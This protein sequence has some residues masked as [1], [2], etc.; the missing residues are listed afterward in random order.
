[1]DVSP[2][3]APYVQVLGASLNNKKN[4]YY[5]GKSLIEKIAKDSE[6]DNPIYKLSAAE[7]NQMPIE[8]LNKYYNEAL[9]MKD[10]MG[11]I[12]SNN[13]KYPS[14][15][16]STTR[17]GQ[18]IDDFLQALDGSIKYRT[19]RGQIPMQVAESLAVGNFDFAQKQALKIAEQGHDNS[20][21][22]LS[23]YTTFYKQALKA[24]ENPENPYMA[25]LN[26]EVEERLKSEGIEVRRNENGAVI[27]WDEIIYSLKNPEKTGIIDG[28]VSEIG[29]YNEMKRMWS[30]VDLPGVEREIEGEPLRPEGESVETGQDFP[31]GEYNE[32]GELIETSGGGGDDETTVSDKD[33]EEIVSDKDDEDDEEVEN[34]YGNLSTF[35]K[36]FLRNKYNTRIDEI[37]A[38]LGEI[39]SIIAR[40][41]TKQSVIEPLM[42][43]AIDLRK[44]LD[45]LKI[46]INLL[47]ETN[48]PP[49]KQVETE[50]AS[51]ETIEDTSS[52]NNQVTNLIN[53]SKNKNK[54]QSNIESEFL[55]LSPSPG[56]TFPKPSEMK[57]FHD[58]YGLNNEA[59]K[60]LRGIYDATQRLKKRNVLSEKRIAK[61]E[62][63]IQYHQRQLTKALKRAKRK[64]TK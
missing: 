40:S 32:E 25:Q 23:M 27:N 64:K 26:A 39:D 6:L 15:S 13:F 55:N 43:E 54:N 51:E 62:S 24:A 36:N 30:P 19:Q 56:S 33:D 53:Y 46:E 50:A 45:K 9:D 60:H 11:S 14:I 28:L 21:G 34:K 42:D 2:D 41:G 18:T 44:Q 5:A 37:N 22:L 38:R 16:M 47:D 10:A 20:K 63:N 52:V 48:V 58:N 12:V 59:I 4:Q 7:I 3:F 57:K 31:A 49:E 29:M 61:L 8:E 1:M 17:A 35:T